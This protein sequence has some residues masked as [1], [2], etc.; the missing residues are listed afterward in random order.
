MQQAIIVWPEQGL[1]GAVAGQKLGRFTRTSAVL[2]GKS[3][4]SPSDRRFGMAEKL[5]ISRM[6][7]SS[8]L[9]IALKRATERFHLLVGGE[10]ALDVTSALNFTQNHRFEFATGVAAGAVE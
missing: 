10:P 1:S 6:T 3:C 7:R 9:L 4:F 2:M 8:R 5:F